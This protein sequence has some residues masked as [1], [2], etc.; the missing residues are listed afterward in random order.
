MRQRIAFLCP[1][2]RRVATIR[3]RPLLLC[4]AVATL[5]LGACTAIENDLD[6]G[7][8]Y[9]TDQERLTRKVDERRKP[10]KLPSG[11]NNYLWRAAMETVGQFPLITAD[12][13]TGRIVTEWR[14]PPTDRDE[15]TQLTVEVLDPD[16][17]R[18]T[19]RVTVAREVRGEDRQW[20]P[21]P[22][23][24]LIAHDLE[25]TILNKARDLR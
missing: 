15:R 18:D 3:P 24:A 8:A 21:A 4:L 17:R 22:A 6:K 16:L 7:L 14:S 23:P 5:G 11:I 10:G 12:P 1:L 9:G 13:R 25:Q 2:I 19:L 20:R